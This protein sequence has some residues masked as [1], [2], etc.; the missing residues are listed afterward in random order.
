M[1]HMFRSH[2]SRLNGRFAVVALVALLASVLP[3]AGAGAQETPTPGVTLK[4]APKIMR[5]GTRTMLSG[6]VDPAASGETVNIVDEDAQVLVT[7]TTDAQGR[8]AVRYAPRENVTVRAQW[9]AAFSNPVA[10]RVMPLLKTKLGSVKIFDAGR[11]HGSLMPAHPGGRVRYAVTRGGKFAGRGT[12]G[13]KNGRWFSARIPVKKPGT[14]RVTVRFDDADHAAVGAR[15]Q[16]R[17]TKLPN[18]GVGSRGPMVKVLEKR[19]RSLGYHINGV[20]K[21]Y[22]YRTSDAMIAFNKVQGRTRTGSVDESTWYALA[23]PKRPRP[24][25]KKPNFHIEV[26]QTK[27][28]LYMVK[29]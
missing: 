2:M 22:D 17:T 1:S 3:E 24:V 12:I 25:S 29:G 27:Q 15:T 8:Y 9:T 23:S 28:V 5:F 10:L 20:N 26:D 6:A 11:V 7:A 14:Y 4:A 16:A 18:L 19:L 21:R 13:L